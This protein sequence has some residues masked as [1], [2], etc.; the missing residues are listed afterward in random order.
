MIPC[1]N[2]HPF[3]QDSI[4]CQLLARRE[5]VTLGYAPHQLHMAVMLYGSN[6][7]QPRESIPDKR[8]TI[9]LTSR[10][11]LFCG[12]QGGSCHWWLIRRTKTS[13]HCEAPRQNLIDWSIVTK[14]RSDYDCSEEWTRRHH[15]WYLQLSERL[16]NV[17]LPRCKIVIGWSNS[18]DR[19]TCLSQN[20]RKQP[21]Q[22]ACGPYQCTR[23]P[24]EGMA[25]PMF[26]KKLSNWWCSHF[27]CTKQLS[28]SFSRCIWHFRS[29]H[30]DLHSLCGWGVTL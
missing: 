22:C 9:Y 29:F 26:L 6:E 30:G 14:Q 23:C 17:Y 27:L 24:S 1:E 28:F 12:W 11:S 21:M 4:H 15:L 7:L 20:D 5:W 13:Y 3:L 8:S 18:L 16:L 10:L 19:T 2:C 25:I